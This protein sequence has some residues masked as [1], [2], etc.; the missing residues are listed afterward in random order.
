MA[1][2]QP[3]VPTV[4]SPQKE[5][6]FILIRGIGPILADRLHKA[7]IRTY[8]Q[9]ASLSPVELAARMTGLSAKQVARQDWIGQ[10]RKLD[11]KKPRSKSWT[12]ETARPTLHQH[13]EN[14]TIEFLLDEQNALRR[15]R[16]VHVQSG[17]ADTWAAWEA[18]QLTDF[19]VRHAHIRVPTPKYETPQI[20]ATEG[21][22]LPDIRSESRPMAIKSANPVPLYS[23]TTEFA[24]SGVET[25]KPV[26]QPPL[27]TDLTG[28]LRLCD[29]KVMPIDSDIPVFFIHE[30]E[31]YRLGLT[32]DLTDI[33]T[34]HDVPLQYK[35]TIICKQVGRAIHLE[36]QTSGTL[37]KADNAP[38]AFV[39]TSLP[40]GIYRLDAFASLSSNRL[41]PG[42][43]AFLKG[44]LLQ[45]YE[46]SRFHKSSESN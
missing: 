21:R 13:Y 42:P 4:V 23:V 3:R 36:N 18:E 16:M 11:R 8:T 31:P 26:S 17:D 19:L 6:D 12:R 7:G 34:V 28:T 38:L 24:P 10:A 33:V 14:F 2:K 32:L 5:D 45:V 41:A 46:A 37:R 39:G 44:G 22:A 15:T 29:L 30:G 27:S 43:M 40:S 9:L 20:V 1:S 25:A 35:A